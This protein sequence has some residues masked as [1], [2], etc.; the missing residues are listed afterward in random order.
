MQKGNELMVI[1][2]KDKDLFE[3]ITYG[4]N[5][6]YKEIERDKSLFAGLQRAI[7]IMQVARTVED[8]SKYSFLH[9][10][11]LKYQLAGYSSVRLSAGR[12]HRLIF[13]EEDDH[14]TLTLVTLDNTHY[15]NK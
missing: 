8:L 7:G 6:K 2:V 9:Y 3:L 10:E 5:R 11:K 4:T 1:Q 12:I 13:V 14:I 15:G